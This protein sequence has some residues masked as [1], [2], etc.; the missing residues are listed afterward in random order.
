M[1][2]YLRHSLFWIFAGL[3]LILTLGY[4]QGH[5]LPLI[6]F[7]GCLLPIA[8]GTSHILNHFLLPRFLFRKQY[9]LFLLYSFMTMSVSVYF[10]ILSILGILVWQGNTFENLPFSASDG[11]SIGVSLYFIVIL[12]SLIHFIRNRETAKPEEEAFITVVSERKSKRIR[13]EEIIFIESLSDYIKIHVSDRSVTTKQKI[14]HIQSILPGNFIRVHR[15]FI[16]NKDFIQTY[17]KEKIEI[18]GSNI[19]ISRTYKSQ[20]MAALSP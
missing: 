2:K 13:V 17:S 10:T 14:S 16:V 12:Y 18:N 7:V 4:K 11:K 15:S 6:I 8:I 5:F 19:P 9:I 20:V 1:N 3:F